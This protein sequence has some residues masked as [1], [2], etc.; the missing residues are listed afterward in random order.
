LRQLAQI[1]Q[2]PRNFGNRRF[3][4]TD[5]IV[6][7]RYRLAASRASG[8]RDRGINISNDAH[9]FVGV[10]HPSF[11]FEQSPGREISRQSAQEQ[12]QQS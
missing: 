1:S 11:T 10:N 2:Q 4:L 8:T 6:A 5:E 9:D 12:Q 7:S 3:E